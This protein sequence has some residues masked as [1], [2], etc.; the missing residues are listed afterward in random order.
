[1]GSEP[2]H[3]VFFACKTACNPKYCSVKS[4]QRFFLKNNCFAILFTEARVVEEFDIRAAFRR[5]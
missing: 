1:M 4:L 5:T 2:L 3:V